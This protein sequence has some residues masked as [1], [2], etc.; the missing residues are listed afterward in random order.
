MSR[1][2]LLLY[3]SHRRCVTLEFQPPLSREKGEVVRNGVKLSSKNRRHYSDHW[4]LHLYKSSINQ[5]ILIRIQS[6][7]GDGMCEV[8]TG[9]RGWENVD[10]HVVYGPMN[11]KDTGVMKWTPLIA[12]REVQYKRRWSRY[13]AVKLPTL[14]S[15][16]QQITLRGNCNVNILGRAATFIIQGRQKKSVPEIFVI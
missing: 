9:R 2:G 11:R 3:L 6:L 13:Q 12:K 1:G 4:K 16:E 10:F 14:K 8:V 15:L 5:R 7:I